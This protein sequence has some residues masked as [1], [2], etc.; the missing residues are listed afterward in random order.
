MKEWFKEYRS[1]ILVFGFLV[2]FDG[3]VWYQILA[4]RS[5]G[6]LE[7]YFLEVGQ[8]DSQLVSLPSGGVQPVQV[9][10]D[11]GPA[12]SRILSELSEILPVNDTYIDLVIMSHPQLDH[13]GGLIDVLK[14]YK[15]GA[16]IGNGRKGETESYKALIEVLREK[17]VPYIV[18]GEGDKIKYRDSIF[19]VLGPTEQNLLS[20]EI[21]NTS[22]VLMLESGDLRA[23][24]TGDIGFDVERQ[25]VQKY[26]PQAQIL[27]VPH[28]G[29]KF[30]TSREFL[31]EVKSQVAVI[32]VGKNSYGHPTGEAI[33]RITDTGSMVLRTD[34]DGTIK[35]VKNPENISV[36]RAKTVGR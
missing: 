27:K 29:S 33:G 19:S 31:A 18:L 17:Q 5:S 26:D 23:L 8:G 21:N 20:K 13:F 30:S 14:K 28:H 4:E 6:S 35:I 25:L 3:V 11:G 22:L 24:Y 7:L 2:V 34:E 1:L 32:G 15:V 12:N 36:F 16:F 10:I 9:L